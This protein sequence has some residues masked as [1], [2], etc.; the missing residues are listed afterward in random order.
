MYAKRKKNLPSLTD[1]FVRIPPG[2][3]TDALV[4]ASISWKL[5]DKTFRTSGVDSDQ[6]KA[7]V[8]ATLNML[9]HIEK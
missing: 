7:A 2:G 3:H 4:E 8:H 9:N 5:R 6:V 1:Y